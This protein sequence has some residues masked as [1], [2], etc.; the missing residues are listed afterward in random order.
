MLRYG[1]VSSVHPELGDAIDRRLAEVREHA[2]L[3]ERETK[4]VP[5]IR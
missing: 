3:E 5:S 2:V 4:P 1:R